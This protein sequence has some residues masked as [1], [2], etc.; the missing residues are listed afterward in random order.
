MTGRIPQSFIDDLLARTDVV[1]VIDRR[2]DLKKAGREYHACCPFHSEKTPSFTVSPSKQFYHCFGCGA[3]GTAISFLM[4]FENLSFVETIESLAH[5]AGVEIPREVHQQKPQ[6]NLDL[7]DALERCSNLFQQQLRRSPEAIDYLKKRGISGETAKVFGIGY[8]TDEWRQL[9]TLGLTNPPLIATGMLIEKEANKTY[10]RFRGRLMF[11][12]TDRRSRTIAFGGRTLG[13][14]E[15]KYLN[16]PETTLFHKG[17]ELY[18]LSEARQHNRRLNK[19]IVVEGYMDVVSLFEQDI[20]YAVATLGTATTP[21]HLQT[22]FRVVP[23]I[24]FCFDGDRAGRGAA[25]RALENA[26]PLLNDGIDLR[27]LFLP[28]GEDPDSY[29]QTNGKPAFEQLLDQATPLA[30]FLFFHLSEDLSIEEEAGKAKLASKAVPLIEKIPQSIY[31]K[32]IEKRLQTLVGTTLALPQATHQP[33][34]LRP[35]RPV[36]P[37]N[38]TLRINPMRTLIAILIQYPQLTLTIWSKDP[39]PLPTQDGREVFEELLDLIQQQPNIT[40]ASLLERYREHRLGPSLNKLAGWAPDSQ[41]S[42][43]ETFAEA[44][45]AGTLERLRTNP[46]K[47]RQ[48]ADSPESAVAKLQQQR[49]RYLASKGKQD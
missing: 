40:T 23:D 10:D 15:P 20:K 36:R 1:E 9:K 21:E 2:V 37:K 42:L 7:Y 29:V 48:S 5:S 35:Q 22:L 43:T 27:F 33:P 14:G 44:E 41:T 24:I 34:P 8:A 18:G 28:Q 26:L 11:P 39:R 38:A 19:I 12:I 6:I 31:R 47:A 16:S 4:E 45:L 17:R 25:W 49:A 46:I 13:D 3:H 32:L 30:E